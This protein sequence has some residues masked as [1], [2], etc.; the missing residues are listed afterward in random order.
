MKMDLQPLFC[1]ISWK[2][3][4]SNLCYTSLNRK[5]EGD[6]NDDLHTYS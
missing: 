1:V 6:I 5:K 2:D 3:F 4:H